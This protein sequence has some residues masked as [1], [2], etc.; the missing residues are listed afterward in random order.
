MTQANPNSSETTMDASPE[1]NAPAHQETAEKSKEASPVTLFGAKVPRPFSDIVQAANAF[2]TRWRRGA[3][4]KTPEIIVNNSSNVIGSI[5]LIAEGLMFK[6]SG[7]DLVNKENRGKPLHYLIDPPKNIIEGVFKKSKIDLKGNL[8]SPEFYSHAFKRLQDLDLATKIDSVNGTQKLTNKWSARSGFSGICAMSIAA[9]LPDAKDTE[10][11][12]LSNTKLAHDNPAGY[13]AKR[14]YQAINPLEW[15]QH[16]RQFSGLGMLGAGVLSF[17]SGFRQVEGKII[18]QQ[19]YMRNPWQMAGGA[20]TAVGGTQLMLAIDNDQ[21]WRNFG[22]IQMMRL[23]TLPSSIATRF[24]GSEQGADY[25]LG[26]QALLQTKNIVAASI[27]GA[28][29]KDGEI[30]DHTAIRKSARELV[31]THSDTDAKN[32]NRQTPTPESPALPSTAIHISPEVE[33]TAPAASPQMAL[34]N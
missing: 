33:H 34:A 21:G 14:V 26:A 5:Q 6:S 10:E 20:I 17:I 9:L 8:L 13:V 24:K 15:W 1:A 31:R 4:E 16:K 22:L 27:G 32:M 11:E 28:E 12:T 18:G 3:I 19:R 30:V 2:G 25:Y 29:K 7:L 23:A